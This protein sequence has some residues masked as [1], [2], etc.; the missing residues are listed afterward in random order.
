VLRLKTRLVRLLFKR[1][2]FAAARSLTDS[3]FQLAGNDPGASD[4]LEWIAALTG[5]ANLMANYWLSSIGSQSVTGGVVAPVVAQHA[6]RFFAY[7]ALGVCGAPLATAR[8]E[9]DVAIRR[10]VDSDIRPG[11]E[12]DMAAR[13]SSLATPCTNGTSALRIATPT[14]QLQKAQQ[15]YA[16]RDLRATTTL[17]EAAAK[18][19]RNNRPGD[20]SPDYIFQDAWLRAQVGDT[21]AAI[22][23]LDAELETLPAFSPPMFTD[24]A[25]AA[26]FGRSM[27]FRSELAAKKRDWPTATR[28]AQSLDALW[29]AADPALRAVVADIK[30]RSRIGQP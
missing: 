10:Y 26:S 13:A 25:S 5:R 28:W 27:A 16:R 1:G 29:G 23:A 21:A 14:D 17:L 6:S 18:A 22:A 15:A 7:A 30:S 19:R 11:V 2:E 8:E 24:A 20:L 3:V 12:A 9:L 4:Q